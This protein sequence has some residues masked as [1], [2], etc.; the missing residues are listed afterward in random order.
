METPECDKL[1]RI[2]DKSQV[3]GEFLEWVQD[4]KKLSLGEWIEGHDDVGEP[5]GKEE[6]M[7]AVRNTQDL[8]AEFFDIDMAK[9]EQ[10]KRAILEEIRSSHGNPK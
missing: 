6:F 3:I 9:V 4:V 7:P 8:L 2:K 10:E 1:S 5:N